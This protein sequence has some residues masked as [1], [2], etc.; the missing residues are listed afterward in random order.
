MM[1]LRH[2]CHHLFGWQYVAF[3]FGYDRHIRRLRKTCDGVEYVLYL[4]SLHF[5]DAHRDFKRII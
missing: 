4:G 1:L 5:N 3:N 2:L